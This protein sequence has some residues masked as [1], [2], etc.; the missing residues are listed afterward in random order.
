MTKTLL[1]LDDSAIL[2]IIISAFHCCFRELILIVYVKHVTV[3]AHKKKA[4]THTHAYSQHT[5]RYVPGSG[6]IFT[7][8][9]VNV[10]VG[11]I[12]SQQYRGEGKGWEENTLE[13]T[14]LFPVSLPLFSNR[15]PSLVRRGIV[16]LQATSLLQ[17]IMPGD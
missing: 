7:Y 13:P 16:Q 6:L 14:K 17:C 8:Q 1:N 5:P 12:S 10:I 4:T 15:I 9:C 11:I 2:G 3:W